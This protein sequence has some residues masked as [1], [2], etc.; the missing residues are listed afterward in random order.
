MGLSDTTVLALTGWS[1]N[2]DDFGT[3]F[4]LAKQW[5]PL[6]DLK[7]VTGISLSEKCCEILKKEPIARLNYPNIMT[8]EQA[9]E[10]KNREHAWLK[11]G[12]NYVLPDGS[13]KSKPLGAV[14]LDAV[15]YAIKTREVPIC[16]DYGE[17]ETYCKKGKECYRCTKAQRTGCALCG[18]GIKKDPDRFVRLQETEPAKIK[19]AFKPFNEGG[20]GFKEMCEYL[21]EYCKT[22]IIIPDV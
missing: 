3:G 2:R 5:L 11:K 16:A 15:L 7:R 8:G 6:L 22:K 21:N 17:I 19:V 12:C 14:S 9:V 10:S 18:F 13:V 4:M 1:C 20:L